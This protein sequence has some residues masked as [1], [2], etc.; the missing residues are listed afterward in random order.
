MILQVNTNEVGF[1]VG[2]HI[3]FVTGEKSVNTYPYYLRIGKVTKVDSKGE[4]VKEVEELSTGKI[5]K[6]YSSQIIKVGKGI[7]IKGVAAQLV[8]TESM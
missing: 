1:E 2:E 5:W 4:F 6:P 7:A 8:L 3:A